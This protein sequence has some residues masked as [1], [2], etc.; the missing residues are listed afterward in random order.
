VFIVEDEYVHVGY[1]G[2]SRAIVIDMIESQNDNPDDTENATTATVTGITTWARE[3]TV[4]NMPLE[5]ERISSFAEARIDENG[6]VW[7]GRIGLGMT[8]LLGHADMTPAGVIP[9]PFTATYPRYLSKQ[10]DP[11]SS[12]MVVMA[13]DGVWNVL[14]NEQ[15]AKL[16]LNER[17]NGL[18]AARAVKQETISLSPRDRYGDVQND[19]IACLVFKL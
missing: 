10:D 17:N 1:V 19:D 14:S 5:R 16:V 15:V 12:R 13:T 7:R 11:S 6:S 18:G 3:T 2:N 8:R 9:T 4:Q